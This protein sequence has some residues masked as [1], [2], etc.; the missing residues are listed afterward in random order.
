ASPTLVTLNGKPADFL[1]GGQQPVPVVTLTAGGS[2]Q[3]IDYKPFGVR[4]T[5]V[6]VLVSNGRLRLDVVPEVSRPVPFQNASRGGVPLV[7]F[8]VRGRQAP[9]ERERGRTWAR[10]GLMRLEESG[11][12]QRVPILGD[13]PL[14]GAL[15]RGTTPSTAETELVILVMPRL[16]EPLRGC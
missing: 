5:F 13:L 14:I 10:G 1:V 2:S 4:L 15:F 8:D 16:A 3:G 6:P 7:R 9:V 12:V 11:N